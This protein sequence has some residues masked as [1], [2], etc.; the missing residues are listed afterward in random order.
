MDSFMS[1]DNHKNWRFRFELADATEVSQY[2]L[3][4]GLACVKTGC[5]KSAGWLLACFA[6]LT[7]AIIDYNAVPLN[8]LVTIILPGL[9]ALSTDSV[10]NVRISVAKALSQSLMNKGFFFTEKNP[11]CEELK[12]VIEQLQNDQDRDVRYFSSPVSETTY[13]EEDL[14]EQEHEPLSEEDKVKN[15]YMSV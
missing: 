4:L 6:Q 15:K 7:Q 2:V 13:E 9:F 5:L 14:E 8:R 11:C 3:P 10:P 12:K 1:L